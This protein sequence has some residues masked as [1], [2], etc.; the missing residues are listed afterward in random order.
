MITY[1]KIHSKVSRQI[2]YRDTSAANIKSQ[3]S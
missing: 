2:T 3:L 1:T